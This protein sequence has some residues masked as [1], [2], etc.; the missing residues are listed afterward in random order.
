MKKPVDQIHNLAIEF[1]E[2]D[3][4]DQPMAR[5]FTPLGYYLHETQHTA[6]E[7]EM[8]AQLAALSASR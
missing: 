5:S 7:H 1:V 4:K 2:F 8:T 6:E 3:N